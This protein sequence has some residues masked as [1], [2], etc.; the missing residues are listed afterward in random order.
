[1]G[2]RNWLFTLNNPEDEEY[3][4]KW[5]LERVQLIVYQVEVGEEG[6]LHLQ[7]Y[8]E[9]E[10][11]RRLSFLKKISPR[12][13][14]EARKGS[15]RQA[16][17][18]VTKKETQL[19][20]PVGWIAGA[21]RWVD[22]V[23][24]EF[25]PFWKQLKL[26]ETMTG[27]ESHKS[28]SRLRLLKIQRKLSEDSNSL[29]EIADE[30][31]DIWVRYFRSFERYLCMKTKPRSFPTVVRVFVGPTGTGKSKWAMDN[32]P[33][34]YWKQRSKWWDGYCGQETVVIDEFYG[35]LPF[36]LML[37]LLDRYPLLVESKGGQIQ[38]VAR[39]IIITS[40]RAPHEWYDRDNC[41]FESL[42]RR[43]GTIHYMPSLGMHVVYSTYNLFKEAWDCRPALNKT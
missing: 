10:S 40:N 9:L 42:A 28:E 29:E 34:A 37:R 36:D 38:F 19:C 7:G 23:N 43:L 8:L 31:F 13:H 12:S 16:L 41:Y 32:Y 24:D 3:P 14:W 39:N 15:R 5:N 26:C 18:Y 22:C 25:L 4:H 2:S 17:E 35:W 30:D 1:M 20:P 11:P 27:K 21:E 6:T 33:D